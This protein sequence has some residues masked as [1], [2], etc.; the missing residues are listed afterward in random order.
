M[1]SSTCLLMGSWVASSSAVIMKKSAMDLLTGL[2]VFIP[3]RGLAA[4]YGST[5][6]MVFQNAKLFFMWLHI[7]YFD[8]IL[9]F[10]FLYFMKVCV[11]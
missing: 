5:C 9:C 7:L 2:C 10:L 11:G 6:L 4:S 3:R 8:H 1:G